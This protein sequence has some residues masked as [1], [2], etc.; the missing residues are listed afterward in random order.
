L[1]ASQ[2]WRALFGY[3]FYKYKK[4]FKIK[5]KIKIPKSETGNKKIEEFKTNEV[6]I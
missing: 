4:L 2:A 6:D 3:N 5:K 1:W